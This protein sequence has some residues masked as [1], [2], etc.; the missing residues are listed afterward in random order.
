MSGLAGVRNPFDSEQAARC[1]A[2]ARPYYHRSAL[3]VA[4]DQQELGHPGLA[5]DI[6]CGT[7]LSARAASD[8]ADH[9]VAVDVSAAMLRA[10]PPHPRVRYLIAAAERL[11]LGDSAAGLATVG[12]ALHWFDQPR[13]FA[14][15][16]RVLRPGAVLVV[17]SDF[18][19]GRLGSQPA[20]A[21]WL[22]T[23]YLPRYPTPN[24][25]AHFA[26][27]AAMAAGFGQVRHGEH[28]YAIPLTRAGLADYLLSQSNAGA[29]IE[30]GQ[31]TEAELKDQ[32]LAE[33]ASFFG[34]D[35]QA[36]AI[37]GMRVWTGVRQVLSSGG[38]RRPENGSQR[39][40]ALPPLSFNL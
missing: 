30:A 34:P 20:F 9:V 1:Y 7:G 5:L 33:T 11:P 15:L 13:A 4:S 12:A 2:G 37:F 23:V 18:F 3:G 38:P 31:V 22:S 36:H 19:H 8:V 21:T 17:Y 25:H 10:A 35:D 6:G 39:K 24:R 14:E 28:E 40:T 32:I 16:A 29:A 26:A 27:D